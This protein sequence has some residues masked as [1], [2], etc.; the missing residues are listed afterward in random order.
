[1]TEINIYSAGDNSKKTQAKKQTRQANQLPEIE[2]F[3]GK[4]E[5]S[6][7]PFKP[8]EKK[9]PSIFDNKAEFK[10]KEIKIK[11]RAIYFDC[12]IF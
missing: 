2:I 11:N 4:T 3:G 6:G 12:P 5:G 8:A 9:M 7:T 1:M 10:P